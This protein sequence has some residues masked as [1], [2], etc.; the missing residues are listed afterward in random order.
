MSP[1]RPPPRRTGKA[2]GAKGTGSGE[3]AI[4]QAAR[5]AVQRGERRPAAPGRTSEPKPKPRARE[6]GPKVPEDVRAAL[7]K[8]TGPG[9]DKAVAA[10]AKASDALD[11]GREK[12]AVRILKPLRDQAP[13]VATIRELLGVSLYRLGRYNEARRE[14]D[15]YVELTGLVDQHPVLMDCLRGLKRYRR[16]EPLWEELRDVSPS[17]ELVAEGRIVMAGSMADRGDLAGAIRLLEKG[18]IEPK[19]P[20]PYHL[21]IWY[22]LADLYERSGNIPRARSL[23]ERVRNQDPQFVD[24]AARLTH[25]G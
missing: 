13:G 17:G 2:G 16:I 21:R 12:D 4:R 25:L 19:R 9:T 23:F 14:L 24:V 15:A 8:A 20:K 18:P 10:L 11:R 5:G 6:R 1:H 7:A 22:A 3:P